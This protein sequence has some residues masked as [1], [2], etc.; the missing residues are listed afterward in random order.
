MS[1]HL[2]LQFIGPPQ[3]YLNDA[4][5]I[6]ERRTVIAL[7]AYLAVNKAP[8]TRE[9]L[10][11]LLWPE[12]NQT[13][14]FANLRHT[15]WEIHK[16][17]GEGWLCA[18]HQ[19][20]GINTGANITLDMD[21]FQ[22]LLNEAQHQTDPVFRI[23]V[24]MNAVKQYSN[25]FLTGFRLKNSPEFNEWIVALAQNLQTDFAMVLNM[26]I[27]DFCQLE[28]PESAIRY[29]RQLI[30]IDPIN[31]ATHCR[32]MEVYLQANQIATA[33]KQCQVCRQTLRK[34]LGIFPQLKRCEH[35][36]NIL[37]G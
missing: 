26:L 28:Q 31:E 21:V 33:I 37:C 5:I 3:I 23:P 9:F 2:F 14:A 36:Q 12:Y 11:S 27:D 15:L 17:I 34:E 20:V 30:S 10:S 4:P 29:A 18:N 13:K 7:L 8:Y 22:V 19:I 32:L 24:L 6:P 25:P 16:C 35:Y 1:P